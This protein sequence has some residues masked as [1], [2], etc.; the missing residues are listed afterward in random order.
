[1]SVVCAAL[2]AVVLSAAAA[3]PASSAP[4]PAEVPVL[5]VLPAELA[6]TAVAL[7]EGALEGS[8]AYKFL[9]A[10]TTEIGPRFAG[11]EA[12]RRAVEWARARLAAMGLEAVRAESVEV[13][14]WE[15]GRATGSIVEPF[16]QSVVLAALGGSVGT[17]PGGILAA[18]IEVASLEALAELPRSAVEGKIVFFN[19]KMRRTRDG[20]GYGEA[21]PVRTRGA[22]RAGALGAAA[23]L[24]RSIGT[25]NHRFAHTGT[26]RYETD[27]P[28][29]P[30]AAL[31]NADADLLAAQLASGRRVLFRLELGSRDLGPAESANVIG[32]IRGRERPEEVVL[33]AAHLDSWDLGTGAIDDGIGCA[34]ISEAVSWIARHAP[35]PRRTIRVLLSAN[36]EFGLSG[37]RAYAEKYGED[38][39][40]VAALESDFGIGPV[41]ALRSRVQEPAMALVRDLGRLLEPLGVSYQGNEAFG[42]AD[43]SP[44]APRRIP[45]FDLALEAET[46]FD[47]HH[48]ADDTLDKVD[49][50]PL[51][52]AVA[53]YA[54]VVWA[55]AETEVDLGLAPERAQE[56]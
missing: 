42:G 45:L 43:L 28:K 22:A 34:V 33:L 56:P 14:R 1:M 51:R 12:D 35:R 25:S 19:R 44:L 26:T 6:R 49:A 30:A 7:R 21:V 29:I 20:S 37:A 8:D 52:Q 48:T 13:P 24:I 5:E 23:V 39:R 36:E 2:V 41:W 15:R 11:T 40:H 16:A 55:L 38:V 4:A 54:A 27:V 3:A 46:Y 47:Y 31:S 18:V 17:P 53:A 10:L 50:A 32:E 9:S